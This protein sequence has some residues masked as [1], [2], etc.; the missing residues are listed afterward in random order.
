MG[1][2]ASVSTTLIKCCQ[3]LLLNSSLKA[4]QI[5]RLFWTEKCLQDVIGKR[6]TRVF[7]KNLMKAKDDGKI[8]EG[9]SILVQSKLVI[10]LKKE[11]GFPTTCLLKHTAHLTALNPNH[12]MTLQ[13]SMGLSARCTTSVVNG[14]YNSLSNA[15]TVLVLVLALVPLL[16][17]GC[18]IVCPLQ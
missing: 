16:S 8:D 15:V 3:P 7:M 13:L 4:L 9:L 1:Q 6:L 2:K 12:K 11:E 14:I 5:L 17:M 10:K 18:T